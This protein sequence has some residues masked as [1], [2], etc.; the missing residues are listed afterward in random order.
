MKKL[1][2][3]GFVFITYAVSAQQT[4]VKLVEEQVN[5]V[6]VFQQ[7]GVSNPSNSDFSVQSVSNDQQ[8]PKAI[9]EYSY[10][11]CE[12]AIKNIAR[13]I[14]HLMESEGNDD[15]IRSKQEQIVL[16]QRQMEIIKPK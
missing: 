14:R 10:G 6:K 2:T 16:L 15:E 8:N 9:S 3:V 13:K 11:E 12:E 7:V 5:G 4:E 1:A